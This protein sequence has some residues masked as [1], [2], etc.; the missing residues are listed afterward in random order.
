MKRIYIVPRRDYKYKKGIKKTIN[1]EMTGVN[2]IHNANINVQRY[3]CMK[4]IIFC[5]SR[6]FMIM[7]LIFT[8]YRIFS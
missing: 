2:I 3:S 6:S 4:R 5:I 7:L 1:K 8:L